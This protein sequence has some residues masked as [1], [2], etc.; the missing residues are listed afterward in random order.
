MSSGSNWAI[1]AIMPPNQYPQSVWD[2]L[3]KQGK[4]KNAGHGLYSLVE[5]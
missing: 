2:E 4:L 3:I 5:Q 1:V